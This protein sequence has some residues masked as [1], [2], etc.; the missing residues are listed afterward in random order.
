[1]IEI[2]I[3]GLS[4]GLSTGLYCLSHCLPVYLTFL[5]ASADAGAKKNI[6]KLLFF[7]SGRLAAYILVGASVGFIGPTLQRMPLFNI[8]ISFGYI[9]LGFIIFKNIFKNTPCTT[10]NSL[11]RHGLTGISLGFFT[12]ISLC[13]PML[14]AVSYVAQHGNIIKGVSYFIMFFIGTSAY[15]LPFIF[16]K[17][18]TLIAK[19]CRI[20][21]LVVSV[22]FIILG[23]MNIA[24]YSK[25]YYRINIVGEPRDSMLSYQKGAA[26]ASKYK[27]TTEDRLNHIR[28]TKRRNKKKDIMKN[29]SKISEEAMYFKKLED[30]KVQCTLCPHFCFLKDGQ[31]GK[32]KVRTNIAGDLHTLVMGKV[33][34]A[35]TDPIEKKPLYHFLPGTSAFSIATAGCNLSCKFC[36]NWEI[37]QS[38]PED[39]RGYEASPEEVVEKA[40]AEGAKSIAYT[41]TEPTV[42]YEYMLKTA[43]LAHEK[44]LKNIWVTAGFINEEPLLNLIPY[45]D[46]ANVDLKA[47][48]DDF[49]KEYSAARL[50]PVLNTLKTL[51]ENN[52]WLEITNLVIPGLNDSD[53]DIKNLCNWIVENL[54]T[55][56]PLHFSRF[57]PRYKMSDK[58]P[59]PVETLIRARKIAKETG[60]KHIYIGNVVMEGADDTICPSCGTAA[61]SREGYTVTDFAV[62]AGSC[63]KCNTKLAGVWHE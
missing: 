14:L 39:I 46:A 21:A 13:P 6:S 48:S 24:V 28:R 16:F 12:G 15:F 10:G 30:N 3:T 19:L 36:Q 42:F 38:A 43:K 51:H 37:S 40:I 8:G 63:L 45:L 17:T 34:A 2:C 20:S 33:V 60:I 58:A 22:A 26:S 62:K 61:V 57:F 29:N 1:M 31:T 7:L 41:Y 56:Y 55:D 59:T 27:E 53:D 47:F 9:I 49:Y 50:D 35:H 54:G 23:V 44:G 4:T 52:V 11:C 5:F 32:C 18:T 25:D